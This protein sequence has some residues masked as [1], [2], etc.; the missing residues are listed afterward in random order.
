MKGAG[1]TSPFLPS[2]FNILLIMTKNEPR[3]VPASLDFCLANLNFP[4]SANTSIPS[5]LMLQLH[6]RRYTLPR[7]QAAHL[8][9]NPTIKTVRFICY[10]CS[11]S[12]RARILIEQNEPEC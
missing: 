9:D 2:S 5:A 7:L 6:V 10:H 1:T 4:N 8:R 12:A 11:T 3:M